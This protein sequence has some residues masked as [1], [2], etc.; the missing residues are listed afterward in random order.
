MAHREAE[1]P[2][3]AVA[4]GNLDAPH[5]RGVVLAGSEPSPEIMH[6]FLQVGLTLRARL[7][8]DATGALT[9]QL[10]PRFPQE[11]GP[12]EMRQRGETGFGI[13]LRLC[14]YLS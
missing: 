9:V 12:Q 7:P 3:C 8:I 2:R 14:C 10:P 5:R 4:L 1:G 13:L 11:I 6:A